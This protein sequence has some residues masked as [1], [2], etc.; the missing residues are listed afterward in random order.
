ML[1]RKHAPK[2]QKS[3]NGQA[4][5]HPTNVITMVFLERCQLREQHVMLSPMN[6]PA[7]LIQGA[8][9]EIQTCASKDS[10]GSRSST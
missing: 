7:L 8:F 1:V 6:L 10:N 4:Q 5:Y 2:P 3:G 9:T